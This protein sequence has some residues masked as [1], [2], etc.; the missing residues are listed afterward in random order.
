M[1]MQ[2]ISFMP[3]KRVKEILALVKKQWDADVALDYAF[4]TTEKGRLYIINREI[5][6]VSLEK[7]RVNSLG[8]YLGELSDNEVRLSIEGSQL[9][10]LRAKRNIMDLTAGQAKEWMQG[11]DLEIKGNPGFQLIKYKDDFLGSGKIRNGKLL[12]YVNK[13]RR[14]NLNV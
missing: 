2:K 11:I 10:G 1:S 3:K 9:I 12:N 8:L 5:S 6:Q 14:L 13:S 7:L 4:L